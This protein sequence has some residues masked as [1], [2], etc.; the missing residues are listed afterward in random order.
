MEKLGINDMGLDLEDV[1]YLKLIAD[2]FNGGPVGLTTLSAALSEDTETIE[3]YIEP[4][5]L[6]QGLITK[7][8][9]GRYVN[10]ERLPH[11]L[12]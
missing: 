2:K 4:Y 9:K 5:L 12:I 10:L 11:A 6:Q 1:K 7:T 3:D 8:T